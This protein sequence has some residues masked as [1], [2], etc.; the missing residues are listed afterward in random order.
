MV[1]S[2]T[3]VSVLFHPDWPVH[4]YYKYIILVLTNGAFEYFETQIYKLKSRVYVT[5]YPVSFPLLCT[6]FC[7]E[8]LTQVEDDGTSLTTVGWLGTKTKN[9]RINVCVTKK[10][11][12]VRM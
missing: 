4:L 6:G 3:E 7:Q 8:S 12:F 11:S 10:K 1:L 5:W 2:D 9:T